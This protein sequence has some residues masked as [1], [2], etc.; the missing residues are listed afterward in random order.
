MTPDSTMRAAGRRPR[1]N[2]SRKERGEAGHVQAG[3]KT[4]VATGQ[5]TPAKQSSRPRAGAASSERHVR[6][7]MVRSSI[8]A[9][10]KHQGCLRALGLRRLGQ[11]TVLPDRPEIRGMIARVSHLV[12]V[13]EVIE[14]PSADRE[15]QAARRLSKE[16][17]R[18][19]AS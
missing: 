6:V 19:E 11:S 15:S 1:E 17:S 2:E 5:P 16:A 18:N 12:E 3:R 13:V 10:P 4:K 7:A 8:G 9:R 14:A